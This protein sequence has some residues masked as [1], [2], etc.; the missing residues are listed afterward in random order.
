MASNNDIIIKLQYITVVFP[1]EGGS[2]PI[3]G[4]LPPYFDRAVTSLILFLVLKSYWTTI[5][6][7]PIKFHNRQ[8]TNGQVRLPVEGGGYFTLCLL[9]L[10][11]LPV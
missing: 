8:M 9:W 6:S 1:R 11:I 3:S 10:H 4:G 2:S 5:Y 7:I